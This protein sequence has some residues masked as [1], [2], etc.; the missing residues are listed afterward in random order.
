MKNEQDV[1]LMIK[2]FPYRAVHN[3]ATRKITPLRPKPIKAIITI[4]KVQ[5]V[6]KM[7]PIAPAPLQVLPGVKVTLKN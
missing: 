7:D 3:I 4:G 5:K 6:I 2:R 1:I